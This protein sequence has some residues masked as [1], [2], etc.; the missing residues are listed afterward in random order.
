MKSKRQLIFGYFTVVLVMLGCGWFQSRSGPLIQRATIQANLETATSD[1]PPTVFHP[2]ITP[3]NTPRPTFTPA[4]ENSDSRAAVPQDTPTASNTPLPTHTPTAT[5]TPILAETPT[6]SSQET[7]TPQTQ[8][9]ATPQ[10]QDTATPTFT[11]TPAPTHTQVPAGQPTPTFTLV[12][13][14]TATETPTHTLTPTH[15]PTQTPSHTPT[16]TQTPQP[17]ATET[18]TPTVTVTTTSGEPPP[19][20]IGEGDPT[21]TPIPNLESGGFQFTNLRIRRD[22]DSSSTLIYGIVSNSTDLPAEIYDIS[23]DLF[24]NDASIFDDDSTYYTDFDYAHDILQPQEK[25][26]FLVEFDTIDTFT[27]FELTIEVD[28]EIDETRPPNIAYLKTEA[29]RDDTLYCVRGNIQNGGRSTFENY[30]TTAL[31]IFDEGDDVIHF[32]YFEQEEPESITATNHGLFDICANKLDT[33]VIR[34]ELMTWG[35]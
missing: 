34:Y 5:I 29:Y 30:L 4:P 19:A 17:N 9:T 16:A 1:I 14:E 15:T 28:N 23:G 8:E 32:D 27:R 18:P 6:P 21:S 20:G 12:P 26:P 11:F 24:N 2:T 25:M 13:T 33:N 10:P 35:E 7:A 31:V 3:T 22:T